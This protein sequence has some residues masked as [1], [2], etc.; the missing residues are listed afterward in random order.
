LFAF[1]AAA[2]VFLYT[3]NARRQAANGEQT[4]SVVVAK[5]EIP[6]G[7]NLDALVDGGMFTN[8][9]IPRSDVLPGA[10]TD[11]S[12]LQ[13][14]RTAYPILAGEQITPARMVGEQQAQGGRYGLKSGYQA[15][16]LTLES[17]RAVAGT[18]QNG[19]YVEAY[20]TFVDGPNGDQVT[21]FLVPDA[22]VLAANADTT[23]GSGG[24]TVLLAVSPAEAQKLVYAQ[25]Q[26]HVWLT[27][28]PPNEDG[29]TVPALKSK[30]LT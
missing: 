12:Q 6:A 16:S 11:A 23:G 2:G 30:E 15:V 7:E 1:A 13:G 18:L 22:Q 21:R 20:G 10:F 25:E 8:K 3:Q 29:A 28:L 4:V 5:R 27:L 26:G 19:D 17:Q 14:Q 9:S 24:F